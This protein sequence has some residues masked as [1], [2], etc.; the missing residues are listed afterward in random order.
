M[1]FLRRVWATVVASFRGGTSIIVGV[2]CVNCGH[3]YVAVV[4]ADD[5][6]YNAEIGVVDMLECPE[7]GL[8]TCCSD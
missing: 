8:F 3:A 4:D 1:A 2:H 5:A 7:C 6:V